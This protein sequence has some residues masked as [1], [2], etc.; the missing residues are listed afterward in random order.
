MGRRSHFAP[1]RRKRAVEADP[2]DDSAPAPLEE[3][4]A[5]HQSG[6]HWVSKATAAL[7][8][9]AK[10]LWLPDY[11]ELF[12]IEFDQNLREAGSSGVALRPSTYRARLKGE[13]AARYDFRRL[14]QKRD[15]LACELHANNQQHWSPSLLARSVTYLNLISETIQQNEG[16]QRRLASTP[17]TLR[18]LGMMRDCRCTRAI[19]LCAKKHPGFCLARVPALTL[20]RQCIVGL[21]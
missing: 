10:L 2:T 11:T 17:V 19:N 15:Q 8:Y 13:A 9:F 12:L 7:Q 21:S 16:H 4:S 1:P 14:Q 6:I 5:E 3:P 18:F 20:P